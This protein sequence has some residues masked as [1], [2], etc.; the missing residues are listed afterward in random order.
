MKLR[1]KLRRS[2]FNQEKRIKM[3]ERQ[4]GPVWK[5]KRKAKKKYY[6]QLIDKTTIL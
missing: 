4:L 5:I 3:A 6:V 1:T 2:I